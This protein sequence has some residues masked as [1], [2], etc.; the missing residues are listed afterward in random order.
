M[1]AA[2]CKAL[3]VTFVGSTIPAFFMSTYSSLLL[4]KPVPAGD[5]FTFSSITAPSNPAFVAICLTGSSNAR[6]TIF[7]PSFSSPSNSSINFSTYG[8]KF[9]SAVPPPATIPSSELLL[10]N[11]GGSV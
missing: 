10:I 6:K 5:V 4:S 2:F 7:A 9:T 1:L 8:A 11:G 3:L